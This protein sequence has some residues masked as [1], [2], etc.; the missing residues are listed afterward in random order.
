VAI[1]AGVF[2]LYEVCA[3]FADSRN[4][5]SDPQSILGILGSIL[6]A[7]VGAVSVLGGLVFGLAT[8]VGIAVVLGMALNQLVKA[9]AGK[10]RIAN[11]ES[12]ITSDQA[13]RNK[14]PAS[15]EA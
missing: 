4:A 12:E 11:L 2:L 5:N 15:K 7:V 3:Y 8:L 1:L 13:G 10:A 14:R 6:R 9:T